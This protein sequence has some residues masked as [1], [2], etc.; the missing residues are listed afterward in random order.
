MKLAPNCKE[1]VMEDQIHRLVE[2]LQDM[3]RAYRRRDWGDASAVN[4]IKFLG[5]FVEELEK[6]IA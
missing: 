3:L 4:L 2:D 6:V 1:A 5:W